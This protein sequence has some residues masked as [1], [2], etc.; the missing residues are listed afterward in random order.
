MHA[1]LLIRTPLLEFLLVSPSVVWMSRKA[2]GFWL[3]GYANHHHYR[4]SICYGRRIALIGGD[5]PVKRLYLQRV[6]SYYVGGY[7]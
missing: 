6:H 4:N 5:T 2:L 1:R 7:L 3:S